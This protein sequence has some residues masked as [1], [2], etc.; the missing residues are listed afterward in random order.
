MITSTTKAI[1]SEI[2]TVSLLRNKKA[3]RRPFT[4]LSVWFIEFAIFIRLL[5]TNRMLVTIQ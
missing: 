1:V 4:A 5:M 2:N 3:F